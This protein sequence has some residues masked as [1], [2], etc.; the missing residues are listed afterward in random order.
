MNT[1]LI[2]GVWPAVH[3]ITNNTTF[4]PLGKNFEGWYWYAGD[5]KVPTLWDAVHAAHRP[6]ASMSWPAGIGLIAP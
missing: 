1:T 5:I 6:V 3:G 2:T 4:D